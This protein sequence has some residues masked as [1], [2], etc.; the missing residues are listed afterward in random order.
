MSVSRDTSVSESAPNVPSVQN[1]L[2]R[3]Y[4][5]SVALGD[6]VYIDGGEVQQLPAV[7]G[8]PTGKLLNVT[9]AIDMRNSWTNSTVTFNSIRKN[10]APSLNAGVI[11][12]STDNQTFFAFGGELSYWNLAAEVPDVSCWQ[13]TADGNGGG[14]WAIFKPVDQSIFYDLTRPGF[15]SGATVDN[16]GFILGGR[17]SYR[18]SPQFREDVP[19]PGIVSFNIS[20][21]LWQNDTLPRNIEDMNAPQGMLTS[22][23]SFGTDGLLIQAGL[24]SDAYNP[25]PFNNITIYDPSEKTWHSQ[26][27]TGEVPSG[28]STACTVGVKGDNGTY[29]IFLYGGQNI[30]GLN[31]NISL[32]QYRENI[33]LDEIYVLS[34]PAFAWFKADYPAQHPRI[35]QTCHLVGKRQMLSIG[36][37]DPTDVYNDT[38]SADPFLQGLGIFDLTN[39]QW[40]DGYNADAEP[41]ETPAVV[42]AWYAANG[43]ST[44]TWDSPAT[45][46]LFLQET[47]STGER[48]ASPSPPEKSDSSSTGAIIG[49]VVG[50]IAALCLLIGLVWWLRQRRKASND[51]GKDP[52]SEHEENQHSELSAREKP[53]ELQDDYRPYEMDGTHS[54]TEMAGA[55]SAV[56]LYG[57]SP[58]VEMSTQSQIVPRQQTIRATEIR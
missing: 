33:A 52:T 19:I 5:V 36:G 57:G 18:S 35:G 34:L 9:L 7:N 43:R 32:T 21:T 22:A 56:E 51:I 49:G 48:G 31:G 47:S 23:D 1:F 27:A 10:G 40:S 30:I 28:R 20:S 11:W 25:P 13:F 50:G 24:T 46:R 54:A 14:S 58:C 26:T 41:Y 3:N 17:A 8:D 2:R 55:Y 45:Q 44:R 16:T 6:F 15:A 37:R 12:P 39:M 38:T 42:K 4:H 53:H 29:E